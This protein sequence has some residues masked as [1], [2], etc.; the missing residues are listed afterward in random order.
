MITK[1]DVYQIEE[2]VS[3]AFV[4]PVTN[5]LINLGDAADIIDEIKKKLEEM[6]TQNKRP[7]K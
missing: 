3:D 6:R 7:K 1:K 4:K 2:I 5:G